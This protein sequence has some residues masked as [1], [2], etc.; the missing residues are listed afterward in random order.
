MPART[1]TS[2]CQKEAY[3]TSS[4]FDSRSVPYSST[5]TGMSATDGMGRRNSM[6]EAVTARSTGTD[7]ITTPA[8]TPATTAMA[9]P[10]P[11]PVRVSP[12]AVQNASSPSSCHRARP[13][14]EAGGR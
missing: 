5:A 12:S 4:S 9:R 10:R 14:S 11:Q 8:T 13:I 3:T 6:V 7:P 2:T 1:W